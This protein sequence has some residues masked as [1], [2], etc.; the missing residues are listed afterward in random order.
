LSSNGG[1]AL[2]TNRY[3]SAIF[4]L[5]DKEYHINFKAIFGRLE[6]TRIAPLQECG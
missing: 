1:A 3:R 4:L 6:K 2:A 5:L